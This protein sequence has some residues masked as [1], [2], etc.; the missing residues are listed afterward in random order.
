[1]NEALAALEEH[2]RVVFLEDGIE[3]TRE[4]QAITRAFCQSD[5]HLTIDDLLE[6]VCEQ[7][8]ESS[9]ERV[10]EVMAH[11]CEYG[12]ANEILMDNGAIRYEHLHLHEHHDHMICTRCK[13]VTNFYDRRLENLKEEVALQKQFYPFRHHLEIYGLCKDCLP[14][15]STLRPLT[16][17]AP[18][19][20][21]C[22][23]T[24]GGGRMFHQRLADLGLTPDSE[25]Q[26][27]NNTGPIIVALRNTRVALGRGMAAKI[28]V[29]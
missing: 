21:V 6:R 2:F 4:H 3:D 24:T 20:R 13:R 8:I 11:L 9:A 19:E 10:R 18:G 25:V 27:I 26:V 16:E 14:A 28:L 5:S 17:V 7:G 23:A 22:I 15:E 29:K 12:L 1:V